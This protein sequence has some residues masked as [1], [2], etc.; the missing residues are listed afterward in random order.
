MNKKI[1]S[2]LE[3]IC[4]SIKTGNSGKLEKYYESYYEHDDF[5][6]LDIFNRDLC[7]LYSV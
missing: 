7:E 5:V 1:S 3:F 4:K 2:L 6:E